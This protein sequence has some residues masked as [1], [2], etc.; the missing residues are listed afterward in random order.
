MTRDP[1]LS[2]TLK[3]VV[4]K[5][6][7]RTKRA[8]VNYQKRIVT[9]AAT[10]L[11][12]AARVMLGRTADR[13]PLDPAVRGALEVLISGN[14]ATFVDA[15]PLKERPEPQGAGWLCYTSALRD[16]AEDVRV[17]THHFPEDTPFKEQLLEL[18]E[19]FRVYDTYTQMAYPVLTQTDAFRADVIPGMWTW[20]SGV[21]LQTPWHRDLLK[22]MVGS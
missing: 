19:A 3:S 13:S 10:Y 6:M 11:N 14:L 7:Q 15:E 22:L 12:A 2:D 17:T 21:V 9:L 18:E 16:D 20:Y 5:L 8:P 1:H 4:G